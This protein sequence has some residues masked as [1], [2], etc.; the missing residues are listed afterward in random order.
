MEPAQLLAPYK[1][2]LEAFLRS[3]LA[4]ERPPALYRMARYHL[5][6]E[7][8]EGA[9]VQAPAGKA[10]RP[11]LCLLACEAVGGDWRRALP[12]AAG[13]ELV[14]DF[15][16][17]HD[18]IQD[19]DRER[20]HRPTVWSVW[21][22]PQAINAGDA[23]LVIA[24]LAVLRLAERGVAADVVVTAARILDE[25]TLEMVEGQVVDIGFEES[26]D[27]DLSAYLEMIEKKTGA[28]FDCSLR[29][30]ALVGGAEPAV[31]EA[32]GR[33]GRLMG[34]AFQVRDDMLGVWGA[35]SQ[36]GKPPAADIRRRKKSLPVVYAL[37]RAEG[38]ALDDLRRAYGG[39]ELSDE[40]VSLVL[41][42]L[43]ALDAQSYCHRLAA[44]RKAAALAALD[45][46]DLRP[47][48]AG[49]LR[50]TAGFLLERDF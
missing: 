2:E 42:T 36:T 34:V 35:E 23:L 28:L 46:Q 29:L 33:C 16:L 11:L 41:R 22:E 20:R 9:P 13:L 18:D 19:R 3:I 10:L 6:W 30:G 44:D 31:I 27:V 14:H 39:A 15:S 37:S 12:A 40:D 5:G 49:R 25:A 4:R 47:D 43:D 32:L 7:D 8:A 26:L 21:G 50:Q 17:V 45:R 48:A 1:R 24:R 38:V